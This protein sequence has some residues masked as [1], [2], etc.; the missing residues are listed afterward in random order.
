M[1]TKAERKRQESLKKKIRL[2]IRTAF[3]LVM[4]IIGILY[5]CG[6][7]DKESADRFIV[8]KNGMDISPYPT[9]EDM[10]ERS[11][12]EDR[13]STNSNILNKNANN[14][15]IINDAPDITGED[16]Q[17]DVGRSSFSA[18][19]GK[20]NINTASL[21]ELMKLNGIGEKRAA[22]IIEYRNTHGDFE[23]IDDIMKVKGIKQGIFSKIRDDIKCR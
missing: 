9:I 11:L 10:K 12:L 13:S 2:C 21:T 15:D 4:L 6:D 5:Y 17:N 20:I 8:G 23:N 3:V 16:P 1:S 18:E 7:E 22:D 14:A 19:D